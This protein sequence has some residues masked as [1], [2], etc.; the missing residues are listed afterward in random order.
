M[1]GNK[2]IYISSQ[3]EEVNKGKDV[4][5]PWVLREFAT[6]NSWTDVFS[7]T[8]SNIEI[9][10]MHAITA[11]NKRP[12][13]YC[14]VSVAFLHTPEEYWILTKPTEGFADPEDCW[15]LFRKVNGRRD[16]SKGFQ[17]WLTPRTGKLGLRQLKTAPTCFVHDELKVMWNIHVDDFCCI[18]PKVN[19]IKLLKELSKT[20]LLKISETM[21]PTD[22][23]FDEAP[24]HVFLSRERAWTVDCLVKRI[25]PKFA[26]ECVELLGLGSANPMKAPSTKAIWQVVE[27]DKPLESSDI[28]LYQ[29]C[30]GKL[31]YSSEEHIDSM[32]IIK[33]LSRKL[34]AP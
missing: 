9:N 33:E 6:T 19:I 24:Q 17:D 11:I 16:A 22:L 32:Y 14:D 5:S 10:I 28:S 18:G 12:M 13:I 34:Q 8:P 7:A 27:D 2:Y 25:S 20:V 15:Q 29:T 1:S 23:S 26:S 31:L 3:W 21:R 30:V 4:R